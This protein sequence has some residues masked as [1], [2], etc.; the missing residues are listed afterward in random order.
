MNDLLTLI[1]SR[2]KK[3]QDKSS[4][5]STPCTVIGTDG[6]YYVVELISDKATYK[7]LNRSGSKVAIGDNATLFYNGNLITENNGYIGA[8]TYKDEQMLYG[9]TTTGSVNNL[10]N[11]ILTKTVQAKAQANCILV[12]N[13]V[14]L[15]GQGTLTLTLYIDGTAH[16]FKSLT[17]LHQSEYSTISFNI[18]FSLTV[19]QH[20]VN[21]YASGDGTAE[22]ILGCVI[23]NGIEEVNNN[24]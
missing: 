9:T 20:T 22:Y 23:G 21:V 18:P 12:F 3:C 5:K 13:S 10:S 17:T 15:G 24:G 19:G 4:L 1:D 7:V 11:P 2:V 6:D 16:P 14:F 8:V